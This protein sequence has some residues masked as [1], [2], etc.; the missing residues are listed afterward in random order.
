MDDVLDFRLENKK[1][2]K[3][4]TFELNIYILVSRLYERG[5]TC[6]IVIYGNIF[7]SVLQWR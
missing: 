4:V 7:W 1:N 6:D 5:S 2:I 3:C